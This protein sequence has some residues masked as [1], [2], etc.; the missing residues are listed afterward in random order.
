MWSRTWSGGTLARSPQGQLVEE[1]GL[2]TVEGKV[3]AGDRVDTSL[4]DQ[5]PVLSTE[6][7]ALSEEVI[8]RELA[9]PVSLSGL[10]QVT[11]PT[12]TGETENGAA[13]GQLESITER[14]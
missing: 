14:P 5:A 6:T 1:R 2:L 10:L 8:A 13:G 4:L 11:D 3:V 7:L 9:T 12:H